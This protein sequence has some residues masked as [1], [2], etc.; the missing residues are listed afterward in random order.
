MPK[1]YQYNKRDDNEPQIIEV[2]RRFGYVSFEETETDAFMSRGMYRNC[3]KDAGRDLEVMDE[4]G[5][6]MVEVKDGDKPP[7]KRQLTPRE[8]KMSLWCTAMG[9]PY[10]VVETPER[11]AEILNDRH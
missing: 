1:G 11:M 4:R 3:S 7:S 8:K 6:F 9:I 5:Y 2:L 10:Y